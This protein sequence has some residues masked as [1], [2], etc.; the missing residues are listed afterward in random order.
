MKTMKWLIRRELWEHKGSLLWAPL[1]VGAIMSVF[2]AATLAI[3][4]SA[5]GIRGTYSING[6]QGSLST[7]S[8][9]VSEPQKAQLADI[10]T[11]GYMFVSAPLFLMLGFIVFFYCLSALY[12][13]RR[14]RSILFWKSLPVSDRTTVLS[15]LA[16]AAG[17]APLITVAV[18]SA[19]SLLLLLM[20]CV[21]LAAK[22]VNVFGIVLASPALYLAPLQ[23][24][25]LT[26]VYFLWALPSVGWLLLVS[27]W[28]RS[29]VLLWAVGA[30]ALS[31]ALLVWAEN[32]FHFNWNI[33]W[34]VQNVVARILLGIMPGAWI[35]FAGIGKEQLQGHA[36]HGADMSA[37]FTASWLTLGSPGLW[38]GVAAGA[39]MIFGAIRLRRWRDEG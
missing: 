32:M 30:P 36:G 10:M 24:A 2:I 15:K 33:G 35:P 25:A 6:N 26:P 27:S 1:V 7:L 21:A 12:E 4:V 14:D 13:E 28:A 29:K 19:T 22:G 5:D 23:L 17:V 38:I 9:H 31:V 8:Q 37:I 39:A 18:A 3:G 20:S 34:Y 11:N 16:V